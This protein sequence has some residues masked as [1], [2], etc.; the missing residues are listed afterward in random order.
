LSQQ[1]PTRLSR[2]K[3]FL[4]LRPDVLT[5]D[6]EMPRMDGLTFLKQLMGEHPSGS[7][8]YWEIR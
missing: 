7:A 3:K 6:I 8:N 4:R 5:L 2:A 1:R